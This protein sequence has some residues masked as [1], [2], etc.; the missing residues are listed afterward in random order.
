[1]RRLIVGM[2]GSTGAIFGVRFLEALRQAGDVESHLVISKWA[3]RTIEHE[4]NYTLEQVRALADVVHSPGD[5]GA[6]VSSG[7]FLTEGMVVIPCSM[8]TLGG[9]AAGIGDHL[10]HRAADVILKEQR[11]LVLVV[12]ETPLSQVHLQNM[13]NLAKMGV[14]MLPPVPAFYNHPQ[15]V[16]DIVNHIVVRVLDQFNIAAHHAKRWDGEMH[17]A[18]KIATVPTAQ[19]TKSG[20]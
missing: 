3:Q 18:A 11:K 19:A 10:V 8:R 15:S 14:V 20:T 5:M 12:R 9:I 17:T 4:T 7:S 1:M 13:L 6:T 2:T 16:D